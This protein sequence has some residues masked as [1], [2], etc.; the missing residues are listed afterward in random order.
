VQIKKPPFRCVLQ[1]G[2]FY[3]VPPGVEMSVYA[4]GEVPLPFVLFEYGTSF[5]SIATAP[6]SLAFFAERPKASDQAT[7]P[8]LP[9]AIRYE[10]FDTGFSRMD[11]LAAPT[12]LRLIVQGHGVRQCVPWH[13][14]DHITDTFFCTRGIARIA[15]ES[16]S[17]S[18]V[19]VLEP[20]DTCEVGHGIP[21]FVSGQGGMACELLV[22]QGVGNYNYVAR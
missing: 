20:G 12:S 19:H 18:G 5:E 1:A 13:S 7:A 15:T 11:V 9:A 21:H 4:I 3:S 8:P 17:E 16:G 6:P 22:L 2:E 10:D 14:H